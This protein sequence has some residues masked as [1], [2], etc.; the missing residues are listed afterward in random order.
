MFKAADMIQHTLHGIK[1][2]AL[3]FEFGLVC[4][5]V[6]KQNLTFRFHQFFEALIRR[7]DVDLIA[8]QEVQIR[9]PH[10]QH[11]FHDFHFSFAPN[12]KLFDRL[13]GV[14]NGSRIKEREAFSLLTTHQESLIRTH[15]CTLFSY[16][17]LSGGDTLLLVNL[18]AINFRRT[19]VY[20]KE[21][22]AVFERAGDHRGAMIV[23]GDFNS[24]N[25]Q[26]M[27]AVMRWMDRLNMRRVDMDRGHLIKSFMQHNLDHIFYRGL[28]LADSCVIDVEKFSDHNALYAR[29]QSL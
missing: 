8:L 26:R 14:L 21:I 15:K 19:A 5:N 9:S 22:D 25:V 1:E 13:Y 12:I 23:T 18:H 7:Y 10:H 24:W 16:Y 4:W 29:F 28:R 2:N 6:H 17:Q 11:C 27:N 20:T 3:P